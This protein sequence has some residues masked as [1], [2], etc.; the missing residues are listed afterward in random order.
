MEQA[1]IQAKQE[2]IENVRKIADLEN[3]NQ[4]LE[5]KLSMIRETKT[6]ANFQEIQIITQQKDKKISSL[7][8]ELEIQKELKE[9]LEQVQRMVD[10]LKQ[11][12]FDTSFDK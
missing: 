12:M 4:T 6:N 1:N 10:S 8:Q 5:A 11:Q 7:I 3:A 9:D 2:A